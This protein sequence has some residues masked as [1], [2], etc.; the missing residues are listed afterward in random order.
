VG[1]RPGRPAGTGGPPSGSPRRGARPGRLHAHGAF[2]WP[3]VRG[4][5]ATGGRWM[6]AVFGPPGPGPRTVAQLRYNPCSL[7]VSPGRR[8]L[9]PPLCGLPEPSRQAPARPTARDG[10]RVSQVVRA[11]GA[12]HGAVPSGRG[13]EPFRAAPFTPFRRGAPT[14][15]DGLPRVFPQRGPV[16]SPGSWSA[17]PTQGP[18]PFRPSAR[19]AHRDPPPVCDYA[20][21]VFDGRGDLAISRSG[22]GGDPRA[23]LMVVP[24]PAAPRRPATC[25]HWPAQRGY[26]RVVP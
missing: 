18:S 12:L 1:R 23:L 16:G 4:M 5:R 26:A 21:P 20:A 13:V 24:A 7:A 10:G 14:S 17:P 3:G 22:V 6:A 19:V 15:P 2:S 11:L 25:A 9:W 8:P